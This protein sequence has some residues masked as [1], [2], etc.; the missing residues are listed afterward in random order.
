MSRVATDGIVV[1]DRQGNVLPNHPVFFYARGTTTLMAI[2][3]DPVAGG[4]I[5]QPLITDDDGYPV[6][7]L[8]GEAGW[9]EIG[10][11]DVQASGFPRVLHWEAGAGGGSGG[12]LT[13]DVIAYV[14]GVA[15]GGIELDESEITA[16]VSFSST[17]YSA[18]IPGLSITVLAGSRPYMVKLDG[19]G[20]SISGTAAGF[21]GDLAIVED[22][23]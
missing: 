15:A 18:D 4:P 9:A 2:Y 12:G 17:T 10:S 14:D 13:G 8:T 21:G 5:T 11:Y 6:D 19:P 7:P 16:N 1:M 20:L 3:N 22:N 23:I